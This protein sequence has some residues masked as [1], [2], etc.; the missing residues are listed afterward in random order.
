MGPHY[1]IFID[2]ELNVVRSLVAP[3]V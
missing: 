1:V 2:Q 3:T